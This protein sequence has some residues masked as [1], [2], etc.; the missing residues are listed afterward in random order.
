MLRKNVKSGVLVVVELGAEWP[1]WVSDIAG[2]RRVLTQE[3]GEAPEAFAAR[4]RRTE[5]SLF[6]RSVAQK[7]LALLCNERTDA[8]AMTSRVAVAAHVLD[9]R[10][11]SGRALFAANA[12]S[13]GRLRH[14]LSSA[15]AELGQA[16]EGRVAV[17][18]DSDR[19]AGTPVQ[20]V[21]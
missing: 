11:G 7:T 18:F 3:E 13:S 17:R 8:A 14:A 6:P 12:S 5:R 10:D 2:F 21:A 20:N 4:A 1:S 15:V 16:H 9:G 19:D